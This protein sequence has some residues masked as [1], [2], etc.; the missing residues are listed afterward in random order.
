[1]WE[2]VAISDI[3]KNNVPKIIKLT[4]MI[5]RIIEHMHKDD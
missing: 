2:D 1:M 5:A 3:L 4:N